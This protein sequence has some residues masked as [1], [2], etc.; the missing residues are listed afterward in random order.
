LKR[1]KRGKAASIPPVVTGNRKGSPP[2]VARTQA[3]LALAHRTK[4]VIA[5]ELRQSLFDRSPRVRAAALDVVREKD[6]SELKEQVLTLLSDPSVIVRDLAVE[7]LGWLHRGE[8]VRASWL[9]PLLEDPA[10]VVRIEAIESLA[11]IG[12]NRALPLLAKKLRDPDPLV[13]S[14]AAESVF[15]LGGKK[16]ARALELAYQSEQEDLARVGFAAVLF[17]LGDAKQLLILLDLLS[18]ED[19]RVRCAAANTLSEAEL[20]SDQRQAAF[21]AVLRASRA[22]LGRADKSTMERVKRELAERN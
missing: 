20:N 7:C 17:A 21:K 8:G 4:E 1:T 10:C 14:Y 11:I 18:A 3:V 15:Q 12:D 22:A 19:Y 9:Y 2:V 6:L 5:D 16:Y 13:R